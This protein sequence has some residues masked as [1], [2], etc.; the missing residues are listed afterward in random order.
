MIPALP[1]EEVTSLPISEET[2][3]SNRLTCQCP[4]C[5]VS[6]VSVP[7]FIYSKPKKFAMNTRC[8]FRSIS[9][10]SNSNP[11]IQKIG[12]ELRKLKEQEASS[13]S[14]AKTISIGLTG[15]GD[16]YKCI[17]DVLGLPL[18]QQGLSVRQH[19]K[20]VN[21]V[22]ETTSRLLDIS[23][24]AREVLLQLKEAGRDLKSGLSSRMGD[25]SIESSISAYV[26][27]RKRIVKSAK[28]LVLSLKQ[29]DDVFG[30]E[31][32]LDDD[33]HRLTMVIKALRCVSI[34]NISIHESLLLFLTRQCKPKSIKWPLVSKLIQ[35]REIECK[36]RAEKGNEL[37][38]A[39]A[40]LRAIC[41][42]NTAEAKKL[43]SVDN[44]LEA[45]EKAVQGIEN[46]LDRISRQLIK[47]RASLLNTLSI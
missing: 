46:G 9:L 30:S 11:I 31:K 42:S 33:Y 23:T 15:L 26:S 35:R 14:A 34:I 24:A 29:L 32:V 20:C 21:E 8:H 27:S 43:Q 47:T 17:N 22:L 45:L 25:S 38:N 40:A 16:L 19:E 36:G 10:P 6:P 3:M 12:Q 1:A 39:D 28:G 13:T 2:H 41:C 44:R 4:I 5:H 37:A 18:T 7:V